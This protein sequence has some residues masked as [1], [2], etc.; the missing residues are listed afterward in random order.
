M[1]QGSIG[2]QH[3]S[4]RQRSAETLVSPFH[5]HLTVVVVLAAAT[6]G[7]CASPT[8]ALRGRAA[9]LGRGRRR[10]VG[11]RRGPSGFRKM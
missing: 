8:P 1:V 6:R 11:G 5:P 3:S 2:R 9:K 4:H 7:S 10:G